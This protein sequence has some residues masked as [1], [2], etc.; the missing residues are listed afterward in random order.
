MTIRFLHAADVHLGYV[1]YGSKDRFN[2]FSKVFLHIVDD[3]VRREVDFVLLAGDLFEKRKV[4][5]LAMRVAIQGLQRLRDAGIP[6]LRIGMSG[7][8][9]MDEKNSLF[10][11]ISCTP[12]Q[13]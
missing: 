8:H 9:R 4:D 5:P 10:P 2:D 12:L 7:A 1:Q 3:A 13:F 11:S 6:V